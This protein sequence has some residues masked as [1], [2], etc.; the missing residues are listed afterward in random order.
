MN[1]S[2]EKLERCPQRTSI[3]LFG[4]SGVGKSATI[5]HLLEPG[6]GTIV[7]KTGSS[8]P[9]TRKTLEYVVTVDSPDDKESDRKLE[10]GIIDTPGVNDP[11]GLKQDACNL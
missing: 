9:E 11:R 1:S 10:L 8:E 7:A 6:D 5:N 4:S 3:L 2:A